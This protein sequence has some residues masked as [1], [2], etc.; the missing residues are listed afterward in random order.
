MNW[1]TN[2]RT[3][4]LQKTGNSAMAKIQ[5]P[6][7]FQK[8]CHLFWYIF[9]WCR[10]LWSCGPCL[11]DISYK[12]LRCSK[13]ESCTNLVPC[14]HLCNKLSKS[15]PATHS[16]TRTHKKFKPQQRKRHQNRFSCPFIYHHLPNTIA[17]YTIR[18]DKFWEIFC[19]THLK[20]CS[21]AHLAKP[22]T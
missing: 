15:W 7:K 13:H 20:K 5:E 17:N 6:L 21:Y 1:L 11:H 8:K 19:R 18:T 16:A 14:T 4:F 22:C 3:P 2:I 12:I 10:I 9:F